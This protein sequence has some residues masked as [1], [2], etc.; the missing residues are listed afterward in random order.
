LESCLT[1]YIEKTT[2]LTERKIKE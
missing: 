2:S 1:R